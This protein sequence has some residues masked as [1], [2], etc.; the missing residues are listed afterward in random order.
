MRYHIPSLALCLVQQVP[1]ALFVLLLDQQQKLSSVII[2]ESYEVYDAM[3]KNMSM[4]SP[5]PYLSFHCVLFHG[6][7]SRRGMELLTFCI[8][9][10]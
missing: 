1:G 2:F 7:F 10:D 8:R 4:I 6:N 5:N 3:N 9:T